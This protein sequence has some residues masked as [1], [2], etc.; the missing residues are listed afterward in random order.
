MF[1]PKPVFEAFLGESEVAFDTFKMNG[2]TFVLFY[3]FEPD[4]EDLNFG[5]S[6]NA[7]LETHLNEKLTFFQS[8]MYRY[9]VTHDMR[10][11]LQ[12]LCKG[13]AVEY[14]TSGVHCI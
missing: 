14:A 11:G 7:F 4:F 12:P 2:D 1:T 13:F 6:K 5:S 9:A 8:D 10:W 3:L